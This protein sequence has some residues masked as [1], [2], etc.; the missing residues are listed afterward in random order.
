MNYVLL[1]L[2]LL[3]VGCGTSST[4]KDQQPTADSIDPPFKLPYVL[5]TPDENVT[6]PKEL[7]EISGLTYYK[8]NQLLCVQDEEAVVYVYDTKKKKVVKDFGF[9]GYGDFE[10][11]EYVN[12]EVYV[13]ESNGN[14][15]RFKPE[16]TQIGRTLTGLPAKTE[17]EGL[18]Y[19]PKTKRLLIAVKNGGGPSS[20]KAIYSFDLLNKAVFKDMSLNDDQLKAAGIDPKTYKPSGIAVHPITG[21]WYVLTSAGKRLLIT[22]RQAKIIYSEEL[23]PKL[24]RQPEGICFAPNG[25]LYIASEG[26]GKK[27]YILSFAYKK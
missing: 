12:D 10:G 18:G 5:N 11:I 21:E 8:N 23:D 7:K 20:D 16:S 6:L 27:G 26:D 24:F 17:V 15:F 2:T 4:K 19:E 14:L 1:V 25:D 13:L 3:L 22:N 9:G